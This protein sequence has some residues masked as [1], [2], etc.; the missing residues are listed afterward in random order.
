MLYVNE[1][2]ISVEDWKA[3]TDSHGY[4]ENDPL[5]TWFWQTIGSMSAGQ[6]KALLFFW[7]SLKC[8]P[9]QGFHG[10]TSRL[11]IHKMNESCNRLPTSQTCF[12]QL[13]FPPYQSLEVMQERLS[14]ITQEHVGSSFGTA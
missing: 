12:Y 8:L 3:H 6:R 14:I 7:T 11:S 1:E 4:M 5:M 13:R 2:P 9:V 10:L